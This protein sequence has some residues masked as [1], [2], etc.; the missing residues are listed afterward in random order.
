MQIIPT[1]KGVCVI[2]PIYLFATLALTGASSLVLA[3]YPAKPV[4]IV[5]PFPPG[6]PST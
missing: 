3:Q 4:R 6:A 5:V 2:K 1:K